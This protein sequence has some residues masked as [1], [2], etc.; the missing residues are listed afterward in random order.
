MKKFLIPFISLLLIVII[1]AV[2][3]WFNI[4]SILAHILSKEFS[5]SVSIGNV[6]ISKNKLKVKDLNIGTP[7]GSKTTSSFFT[8]ELNVQSTLKDI[9]KES[10]TIE[11]ITLNN[12][13]I[14]IEFYNETGTDNNWSRI[15]KI[16]TKGKKESHRKYLIKKLTLNNISVVL[17]KQNGQKQTFPTLEKLEF[18]NISDETGFPIDEI[19]KAIAQVILKSVFQKFN[20]LKLLQDLPPVQIIQ[21]VIPILP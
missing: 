2:I 15:M 14:A 16:P 3:A 11:S 4:P 7:K 19:E 8:K 1:I 18:Y 9:K 10:L 6:D 17:T 20:L 12:N 5:V 21:K 13:I